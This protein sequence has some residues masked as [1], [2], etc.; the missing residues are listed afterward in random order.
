MGRSASVLMPLAESFEEIEAVTVIDVLR[1]AGIEVVVASLSPGPVRGSRG[2]T[3]VPDVVIDEVVERRFDMVV[4][5]GGM[6]GART[7]GED[8]RIGRLVR[9]AAGDGR[10]IG[11]ICAAPAMVLAK[12]GLLGESPATGHPSM[13]DAL[14]TYRAEPVVTSGRIVTSQ[15]PGTAM[16]FALTLVRHL[17]GDERARAVAGPMLVEY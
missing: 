17:L 14:P 9:Q 2:V 12:N 3:V 15:G 6:P 5:P 8:P 7:L 13:K 16:A 1:R 10:W 11:A 4:L